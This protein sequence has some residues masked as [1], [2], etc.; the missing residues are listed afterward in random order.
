MIQPDPATADARNR[1]WRTFLQGLGIDVAAA[2]LLAAGP[3]VIGS[4]FAWTR[5]YWLTLAGLAGKTAIQTAVS[6]GMRKM[7]PPPGAK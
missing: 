1:A 3:I 5:A 4:D 2:V 6:Y 7:L